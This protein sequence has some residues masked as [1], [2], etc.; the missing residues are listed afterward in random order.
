VQWSLC[1]RITRR[2][3]R[4]DRRA[5]PPKR[6]QCCWFGCRPRDGRRAQRI[7]PTGRRLRA[8]RLARPRHGRDARQQ[9]PT[10][11]RKGGCFRWGARHQPSLIDTLMR[12]ADALVTPK[13][14]VMVT[15]RGAGRRH[16][17]PSGSPANTDRRR[18]IVRG[19][20]RASRRPS[21]AK[22]GRYGCTGPDNTL[23]PGKP[24]ATAPVLA[25]AGAFSF[26]RRS[27]RVSGVAASLHKGSCK[28]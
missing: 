8:S 16:P 2:S 15:L 25:R 3:V 17:S 19:H 12:R 10:A 4:L 21:A 5:A 6:G 13:S 18:A 28:S 1:D 20:T 11:A 23:L 7:L 9:E 14:G 27:L 26:Q 22:I 24:D